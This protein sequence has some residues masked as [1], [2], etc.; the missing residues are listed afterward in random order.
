MQHIWTCTYNQTE[1]VLTN[2]VCTDVSFSYVIVNSVS[3][4]I[5]ICNHAKDRLYK[6]CQ[7]SKLSPSDLI[8][9]LILCILHLLISRTHRVK[10]W[11]ACNIFG[12]KSF[13][14]ATIIFCTM[15]KVSQLISSCSDIHLCPYIIGTS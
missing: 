9:W 3:L 1:F 13:K 7:L 4:S 2:G 5:I 8:H 12:S 11:I 15:L 10:K 14:S 6:T